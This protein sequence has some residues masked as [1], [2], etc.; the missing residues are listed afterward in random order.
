MTDFEEKYLQNQDIW[1]FETLSIF[2][3]NN[4]FKMAYEF[5]TPIKQTE[6]GGKCVVVGI[7][8]DVIKKND[9]HGKQF[10]FLNVYS[11]FGLADVTVWHSQYKEYQDL[12]KKSNQLAMLCKKT[13]DG[14]LVLEKLKT[15]DQWLK[16]KKIKL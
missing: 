3:K 7:V 14:R 13:E 5:I 8:S 9:R 15:Y 12:L 4:P 1:E 11:T 16:D 6:D 2:L 10:A